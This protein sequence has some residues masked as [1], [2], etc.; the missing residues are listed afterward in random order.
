MG[1]A[2]DESL[3]RV[4]QS[5]QPIHVKMAGGFVKGRRWLQMS[6]CII[7]TREPSSL[8]ATASKDKSLSI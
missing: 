2:E 3:K 7:S 4:V 1:A 8:N 5:S 6:V